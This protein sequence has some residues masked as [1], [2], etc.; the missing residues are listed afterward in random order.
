ML[1]P[2]PF[3]SQLGRALLLPML[4]SPKSPGRASLGTG[5]ADSDGDNEDAHNEDDLR[6][7]HPCHCA[8]RCCR[9]CPEMHAFLHQCQ[10]LEMFSQLQW[11]ADVPLSVVTSP[12]SA[13]SPLFSQPPPLGDQTRCPLLL[14]PPLKHQHGFG[15]CLLSSGCLP[16]WADPAAGAGRG[17]T[18]FQPSDGGKGAVAWRKRGAGG[19]LCHMSGT[20]R[21]PWMWKHL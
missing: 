19:F 21:T 4:K 1:T 6:S 15:C 17:R 12:A 10:H 3:P 16:Q 11:V 20:V 8:R 13:V 2:P 14:A 5:T 9:L 7:P 18:V